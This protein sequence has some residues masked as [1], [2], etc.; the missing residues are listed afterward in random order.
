MIIHRIVD[1]DVAL[2]NVL[3]MLLI[4]STMMTDVWAWDLIKVQHFTGDK[5]KIQKMV[6][7]SWTFINDR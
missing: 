3:L 2:S 7:M 5:A 1:N 4:T 6:Q